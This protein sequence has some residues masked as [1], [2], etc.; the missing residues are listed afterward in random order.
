MGKLL[1]TP[2]T[3]IEAET[4][5]GVGC[6]PCVKYYAYATCDTVEQKAIKS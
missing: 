3:R 6:R 1:A 2:V 5:D 4:L